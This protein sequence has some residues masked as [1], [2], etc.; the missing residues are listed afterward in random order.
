MKKKILV[1]DDDKLVAKSIDKLL[2][3]KGYDVCLAGN[4]K[5][6]LNIIKKD[7]FDLIISDM[8]MPEMTGIETIQKIK[9]IQNKSS[10]SKSEFMAITGYASDDAPIEG[11]KL[12]I[13]N[14]ILKPFES[15]RFL[16]TVE[17]CFNVNKQELSPS[18]IEDRDEIKI[19]F[20]KKYFSIE[21]IVYLKHTN[22]M[23]NTYFANYVIWQGEARESLLLSHPHFAD[24][25]K[26]NQFVRMITHSVYHR[27]VQETTFGDV[28]EI[29]VMSREIKHCSFVL[30]FQFF[31]KNTKAF[32]GEGWQ[33]ITFINIKNENLYTIPIFIKELILPIQEENSKTVG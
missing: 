15:Q 17:S 25:M 24:E 27:F 14:F 30:V 12:G 3:A 29:R 13:T 8:R 10:K 16:E 31:N 22:V 32:I 20:K 9:E 6:A 1:I 28:I 26:K 23:G 19:Q 4:G 18:L 11:A 7:D 33:R 21:R 2:K 5:E